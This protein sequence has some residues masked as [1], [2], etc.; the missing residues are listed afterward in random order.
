MERAYSFRLIYLLM[1]IDIKQQVFSRLWRVDLGPFASFDIESRSRILIRGE[2]HQ[3]YKINIK[4]FN[5][6]EK[7][8]YRTL[9]ISYV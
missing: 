5:A 7:K 2:E 6:E 4:T 8:I 3:G 9:R 1:A